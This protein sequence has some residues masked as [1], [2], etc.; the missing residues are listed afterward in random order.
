MTFTEEQI[1]KVWEKA[2]IVSR[3]NPSMFRKDSYGAW[4]SWKHYWDRYSDFG[5]E[6][7]SKN[8]NSNNYQFILVNLYPMQWENHLS[9][10]EGI[11]E[12]FV[13][14]E[15]VRNVGIY[16]ERWNLKFMKGNRNILRKWF[17]TPNNYLTVIKSPN[18]CSYKTLGSCLKT[19]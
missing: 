3:N 11:R 16:W 8:E 6:I 13:T 19:L 9:I 2:T 7:C 10:L 17:D 18:S 14:S 12:C 5:W 4:I 15:N 1:R